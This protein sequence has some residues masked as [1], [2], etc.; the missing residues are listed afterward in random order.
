MPSEMPPRLDFESI[1]FTYPESAAPVLDGLSF[2]VDPGAFVSVEGPSGCGK[3]TLLRLACRLENPDTGTIFLDGRPIE[4]LPPC[5]LRRQVCYVQQTPV[6]LAGTVRTNLT[7][8]FTLKVNADLKAPDDRDLRRRLD[9]FSL[10]KV[11]LDHKALG[12]SV[13]QKQRLCVLRSMLLGPRIL[14]LDEPTAALD[15]DNARRVVEAVVQLNR[16]RDLTV[17]MVSHNPQDAAHATARI[18][19]GAAP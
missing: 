14:L 15:R 13:G 8:P 3:S 2:S 4:A 5:R 7:L 19:L 18:R 1:T 16:T 12:L 17:V 11:Y 6:L 10:E 9:E